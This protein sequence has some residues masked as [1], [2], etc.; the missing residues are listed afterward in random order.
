M[1][2]HS[3]CSAEDLVPGDHL[4][5]IYETE[6]ERSS[7]LNDYF[8]SGL[9]NNEKILYIS[10]QSDSSTISRCLNS[11]GLDIECYLINGQIKTVDIMKALSEGISSDPH[12]IQNL[13]WS[14]AKK[15]MAEGYTALRIAVEVFP[16]DCT[17]GDITKYE[18][19]IDDFS[20]LSGEAMRCLFLC[21]YDQSRFD[22]GIIM[23][24]LRCHPL[25]FAGNEVCRNLYYIPPKDLQSYGLERAQ[26]IRAKENLLEHKRAEVLACEYEREIEELHRDSESKFRSIVEQSIDGIV[27]VDEAG[28]IIE[29]NQGAEVNFGLKRSDVL[30]RPIWDVQFQLLSEERK[31]QKHLGFLKSS[32]QSLLKTGESPHIRRLMEVVNTRP[33][34]RRSVIQN[35]AFPI[36]T[37]R[38]FMVCTISR[39]I[40]RDKEAREALHHSEEKYRTIIE[41][42]RDIVYTSSPDGKVTF[43]SPNVS[44]AGYQPED[45][46][47]HD[48]SEFIYPEDLHH[49]LGDL[50][51]A[52][53]TGE[54][55]STTFRLLRKDGSHIHVEETGK[56]VI[57]DGRIIQ[58]TGSIRDLTENQKAEEALLKSEEKYRLLVDNLNE[59]IWAIDADANTTFVNN[60]MAEMLGYSAQ[61]MVGRSLFS[62]MD[63]K[64]VEAASRNMD[65]RK[66]GIKEKHGFEFI[67]RDGSR[68]YTWMSTS[69]IIDDA[70][71]YTG[72]LAAVADITERKLDEEKLSLSEARY[73]MLFENS[74]IGIISIDTRGRILEANQIL[75]EL[76]GLPSL[77]DTFKINVLIYQPLVEAGFSDQ[78]TRC[79]QSGQV[80][81]FENLYTSRHGRC[82]YLKLKLTPVR[83]RLGAIRGAQATVEDISEHK[84]AEKALFENLQFLQRLIDTIP[85]PVYYQNLRCV[86]LGC[87]KA[88]EKMFSLTREEIIGMS[89]HDLNLSGLAGRFSEDIFC[90]PGIQMFESSS[91]MADGQTHHFI[92]YKASYTN[93]SGS[94]AG[95]VGTILDITDRKRIEDERADLINELESRNAEME[96][97]VYTISH[98][99]RSPLVTISGFMG[100]LKTDIEKESRERV[101]TDLRMIDN[102]TSRMD[103]LLRDTLELSRIG[104]VA[105]PEEAIS[106]DEIF[107][108]ALS[109]TRGKINIRGARVYK[110]EGL[111]CIYVDRMRIVEVMV[112]LIENSLKYMGNQAHPEIHLGS[113]IRGGETVFFIRDNGMGIEMSQHEKVFEL[114]YKVD[115][116]SDGT[117]TGLAIVKRIIEVHGGRIW[118][119][120]EKGM[121]C[122][123]CFTLPVV[124]APC[125]LDN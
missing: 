79:I 108:E 25:V 18:A 11:K 38:G 48:L 56:P 20:K 57:K 40:T 46:L 34:G 4:C 54:S 52:L 13:I 6:G 59:G 119:E 41:N 26:L 85:N 24:V 63:E 22:P 65:R 66:Q 99:L 97:F 35:M 55:L 67:R 43:I 9:D 2:R 61:D 122:T 42:I 74:P 28:A 23:D 60:R 111:P 31:T 64:G 71:R 7:C 17:S 12:E 83:D 84:R 103:W 1:D 116:K 92:N 51:R 45:V 58:I 5:M 96:R 87:N 118:I 101:I 120:S 19:E 10:D 102:A 50:G 86:L 95:T 88:F 75:L 39:D 76:L 78:F 124:N 106:M 105:N 100:L 36:K 113:I 114:F 91:V 94:V 110:D 69:P 81:T 112:N 68:A 44:N 115:R 47:G 37:N 3:N 98:D 62:F 121:G 14:E 82:S 89:I 29:W 117:G 104:R 49:V 21:L 16:S 125:A 33:D 107:D 8:R 77:D 90:N 15:A 70:G 72:A 80:L 53:K 109:Q 123:V 73:K 27:L 93:S 32:M 30:N